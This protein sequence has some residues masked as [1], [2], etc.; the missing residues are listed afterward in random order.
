MSAHPSPNSHS[1][2]E[3][4][5]LGRQLKAADG[6]YAGYGSP[7][8]GQR[9]EN[10]ELVDDPTEREVVELIRR[11][12][13]SGK[14]LQKIADWLNQQGYTTKRGQQWQRISVKRVL[15]RLYGRSSRMSE[16]ASCSAEPLRS[17]PP[18]SETDAIA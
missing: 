1:T 11:H 7:A 17:T 10:G 15:D 14:S 12:H 9:S 3:R 4:L 5:E 16:L 2:W 18:V 6:G 13:K 8:F